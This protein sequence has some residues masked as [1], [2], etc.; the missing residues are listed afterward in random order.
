MERREQEERKKE[1][2]SLHADTNLSSQV[3][4]LRL[5]IVCVNVGSAPVF[6]VCWCYILYHTIPIIMAIEAIIG[7]LREL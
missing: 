2:K 5:N 1:K 4:V 7:M 6:L 3:R